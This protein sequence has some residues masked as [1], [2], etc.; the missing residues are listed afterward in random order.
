MSSA[1]LK[2]Q[3]ENEMTFCKKN[4]KTT[5]ISARYKVVMKKSSLLLK[6][7]SLDFKENKARE[8]ISNSQFINIRNITDA[9]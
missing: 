6:P 9:A 5:L 8:K 7:V 4:N 1:F 2:K 3:N